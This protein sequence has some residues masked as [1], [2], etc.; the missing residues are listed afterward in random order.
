MCIAT[1]AIILGVASTGIATAGAIEQ[2]NARADAAA[3]SAQVAR[4]NAVVAE[5]DAQYALQAGEADA[6]TSGRRGA[7]RL[8][9][10]K[11]AQAANNLDVN[12]GSAVD[13][14]A[15]QAKTNTLDTLTVKNNALLK[16]YGYRNQGAGY[17]ATAGLQER[18]GSAARTAGYLSG[19]ATLLGGASS[20]GFKWGSMQNPAPDVSREPLGGGL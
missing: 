12:S 14:R 11:T 6:A 5:Q 7:D 1:A 13:V 4:N 16:A 3:Y 19:G 10:I 9:A 17:T 8:A 20:L 2:G 15:G 18:E